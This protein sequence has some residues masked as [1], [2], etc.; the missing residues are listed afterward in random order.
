M[1]KMFRV[2]ARDLASVDDHVQELEKLLNMHLRAEQK[3]SR[4][5]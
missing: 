3:T 2:I 1:R 4:V 5:K